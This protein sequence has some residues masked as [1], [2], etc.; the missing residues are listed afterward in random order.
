MANYEVQSEEDMKYLVLLLL[1]L[2]A[3]SKDDNYPQ[4]NNQSACHSHRGGCQ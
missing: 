3:C 1:L 4:G 2:A